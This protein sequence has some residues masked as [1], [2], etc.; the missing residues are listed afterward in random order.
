M[1]VFGGGL[2]S[3]RVVSLASTTLLVQ[4]KA[5][6]EGARGNEAEPVYCSSHKAHVATNGLRGY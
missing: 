6:S 4:A 3:V 1:R 2:S 5:R